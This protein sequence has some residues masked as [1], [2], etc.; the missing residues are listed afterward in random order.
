MVIKRQRK[1]GV[2]EVVLEDLCV[3]PADTEF[4][5]DWVFLQNFD[6]AAIGG[7]E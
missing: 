6:V 2:L 1:L 4:A 5:F 7:V 3:M